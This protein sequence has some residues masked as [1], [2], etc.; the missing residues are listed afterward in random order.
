[1]TYFLYNVFKARIIECT[2]RL[3]YYLI[4]IHPIELAGIS[5]RK[6]F[7]LSFYYFVWFRHMNRR[8]TKFCGTENIQPTSCDEKIV[9]QYLY[10]L[11]FVR[12]L[13]DFMPRE[14]SQL[15]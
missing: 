7:G 2:F 1:M 4:I 12:R 10:H 6:L 3:K 5:Q 11:L 13:S 9:A 15:F 14:R 8:I